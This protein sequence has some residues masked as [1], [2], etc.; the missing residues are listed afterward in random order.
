M[1]K[2]VLELISRVPFEALELFSGN[3]D[4]IVVCVVA[5]GLLAGDVFDFSLKLR[6]KGLVHGIEFPF[7]LRLLIDQLQL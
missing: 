6:E 4:V 1:V 5:L 2:Q 3:S 7:S